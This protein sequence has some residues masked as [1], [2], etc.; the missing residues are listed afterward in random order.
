ME[1]IEKIKENLE[2]AEA[3]CGAFISKGNKSAATRARKNL[4]E[5]IK[6]AKEARA[7]IQERKNSGG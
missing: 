4:M 1:S 3:E 5:I 6:L 2:S 7:E